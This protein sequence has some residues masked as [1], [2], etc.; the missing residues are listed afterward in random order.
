MR[1]NKLSRVTSPLFPA[2]F[3]ELFHQ[4]WG[5]P[6]RSAWA[7]SVDVKETAET[8]VIRAEIPGIDI[9]DVHV[10]VTADSLTLEGEKKSEETVAGETRHI[11]ERVHGKFSR[12]FTFPGAI[13]SDDVEAETKNGILTVTVKKVDNTR[14]IEIKGK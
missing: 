2:S 8:F 9:A 10:T 11:T 6:R 13:A 7:P 5:E 3:D 14:R 4:V 1:P 12:T